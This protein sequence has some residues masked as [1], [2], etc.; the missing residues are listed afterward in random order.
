VAFRL[1]VTLD[2]GH[3][4][5]LRRLAEERNMDENTLA[6]SPLLA[7]LDEDP[8]DQEM[9]EL[10]DLI[11]GAWERVEQGLADARAGRITELDDL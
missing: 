10:L 6:R 1:D 9:T 5:K 4:E 7:L 3:A 2:D 8:P 11:P